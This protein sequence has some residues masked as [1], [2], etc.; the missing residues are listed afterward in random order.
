MEPRDVPVSEVMQ[1]EFMHLA[2]DD[3]LDFV[4]EIMDLGRVRHFP[5]LEDGRLVGIVSQRDLLAAS[6]TRV[7]DFE[8]AHRRAFLHSVEVREVMTRSVRTVKPETT[9]AEVA[10]LLDR[11]KIGCVVVME[12]ERAVGLV[13]ETDLLAR[14]YLR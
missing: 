3:G 8:G 13:T 7:L 2:P 14:A 11:H 6:L 1:R 10:R 12:G 5:V 4:E 9:L